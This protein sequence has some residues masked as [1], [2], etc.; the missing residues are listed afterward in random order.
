MLFKKFPG[1]N[2]T[3]ILAKILLR[4]ILTSYVYTTC[5]EEEEAWTSFNQALFSYPT[6]IYF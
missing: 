4:N 6:V 2:I 3:W 1:E 5:L